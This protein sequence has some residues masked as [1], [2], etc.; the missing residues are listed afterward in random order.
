MSMREGGGQRTSTTVASPVR[1]QA[2]YFVFR[3]GNKG[4]EGVDLNP[5]SVS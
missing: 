3:N 4:R 1:K 2:P 5:L